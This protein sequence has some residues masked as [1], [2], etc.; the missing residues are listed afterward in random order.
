MSRSLSDDDIDAIAHRLAEFSGLTPDEHREHHEAFALFIESQRRKAQRWD[1]I[2]EQVGGW[3]FAM[4][5]SAIK[6]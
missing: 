5:G 3:W 6:Q 1:S 2:Q 4:R